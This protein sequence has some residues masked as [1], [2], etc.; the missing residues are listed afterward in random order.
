MARLLDWDSRERERDK[1]LED[2]A[3]NEN[4]EHIGRGYGG[5]IVQVDRPLK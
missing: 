1:R 2:G 4:G 3:V 5:L